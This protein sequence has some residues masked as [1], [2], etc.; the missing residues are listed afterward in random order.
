M[1]QHMNTSAAHTPPGRVQCGACPR[2]YK[3]K[4]SH[5]HHWRQ[6]HRGEAHA[7]GEQA[8]E[9]PAVVADAGVVA[10]TEDAEVNTQ[11]G[12]PD[13]MTVDTENAVLSLPL[14]QLS[15]ESF[16]G[17]RITPNNEISVYDAI[18]KFTGCSDDTARRKFRLQGE[19]T[20]RSGDRAG[21]KYRVLSRR[22]VIDSSI[23]ISSYR[24]RD[25]LGR[26]GRPTFV[27][28]FTEL[29]KILS[30]LPGKASRA[31]RAQNA[32]LAV[33]SYLGDRRLEQALPARREAL[34][35]SLANVVPDLDPMHYEVSADCDRSG[36]LY[37][38]G[39]SIDE[40]KIGYTRDVTNRMHCLQTGNARELH[41]FLCEF[42][43][44]ARRD[45]AR[46]HERYQDFRIRGEWFNLSH[47]GASNLSLLE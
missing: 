12:D 16:R 30:A 27:A 2:H 26:I 15:E 43:M 7:A 34:P 3:N 13:P 35:V 5:A 18:A 14:M 8:A 20:H 19:L 32:S 46:V 10:A 40:I 33:C 45:E 28:S 29:L 4:A 9:V 1:D 6:V 36:Y 23:R 22:R 25:N 37:M 21:D 42:S 44:N 47:V 39:P 38:I 11:L 41:L 24:F 31:L 17:C